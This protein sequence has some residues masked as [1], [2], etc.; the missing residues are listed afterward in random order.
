MTD[1]LSGCL[2]DKSHLIID[3]DTKYTVE[4]RRMIAERGLL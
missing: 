1:D 2:V 4:F 3:R